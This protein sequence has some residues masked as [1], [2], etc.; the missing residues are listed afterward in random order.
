[1]TSNVWNGCH[2]AVGQNGRSTSLLHRLSVFLPVLCWAAVPTSGHAQEAP[3]CDEPLTQMEMTACASLDYESADA[4]LN[5][6]W[7]R[8]VEDARSKDA[9]MSDFLAERD[10]PST[11]ET[12]RRAQR[13]WI[14]YRDAECDYRAYDALGG[15]MQPMIGSQ[16]RADLTRARIRTLRSALDQAEGD[17]GSRE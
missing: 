10:I 13:A 3:D 2:E 12:L 14:D 4:D 1:M 17:V 6:L 15:S 5:E 8:L 11:E 9:A 7:P 16:C